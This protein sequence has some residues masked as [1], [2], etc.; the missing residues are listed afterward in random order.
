MELEH[1]GKEGKR[2]E[3]FYLLLSFLTLFVSQS[4]EGQFESFVCP[5]VF[6]DLLCT[7]AFTF[8]HSDILDLFFCN[9][10]LTIGYDHNVH[11]HEDIHE[12]KD[13]ILFY[14]T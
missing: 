11:S 3:H 13:V 8:V 5:S 2:L 14:S 6:S 12:H 4:C 1:T 9:V 10:M 7:D